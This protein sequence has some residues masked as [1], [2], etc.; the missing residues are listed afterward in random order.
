[1]NALLKKHDLGYEQFTELY[2]KVKGT[3][4]SLQK[5]VRKQFELK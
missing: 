3:V 1:M 5:T 2:Y 4:D